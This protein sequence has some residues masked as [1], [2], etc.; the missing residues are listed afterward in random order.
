MSITVN[1]RT[2]FTTV[3]ELMATAPEGCGKVITNMN[4]V[5]MRSIAPAILLTREELIAT[6]YFRPAD[7]E[8][9]AEQHRKS[10]RAFRPL[11]HSV[12]DTAKQYFGGIDRVPIEALLILPVSN[13]DGLFHAELKSGADIA[14]FSERK[15]PD[16]TVG[17]L[18]KKT[19]REVMELYVPLSQMGLSQAQKAWKRA[20][21]LKKRLEL[22]GLSLA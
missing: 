19:E 2:T 5:F 10:K 18:T 6:G 11:E 15:Y 4:S 13:A 7:A 16:L 22:W 8:I 1:G 21:E 17:A 20:G 14:L 3:S 12:P 9:I